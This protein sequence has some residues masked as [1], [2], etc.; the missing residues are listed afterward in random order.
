MNSDD[1]MIG[2]LSTAPSSGPPQ[3]RVVHHAVGDQG[4]DARQHLFNRRHRRHRWRLIV[5]T[6]RAGEL[7][8][9]QIGLL[10]L[11]GFPVGEAAPIGLQRRVHP[12]RDLTGLDALA[13][14]R[15]LDL[16]RELDVPA[17]VKMR[18][19]DRHPAQEMPNPVAD[20]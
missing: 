9:V 1:S 20:G 7:H 17:R 15:D 11:G 6:E 5:E 14:G 2:G 16:G 3:R 18:V 8:R 13:I 10:G 12:G 4:L 19:L